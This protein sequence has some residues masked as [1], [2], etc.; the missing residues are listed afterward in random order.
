MTH[1]AWRL[2]RVA[3][4]TGSAVISTGVYAQAATPAPEQDKSTTPADVESIRSENDI[5]VT[6]VR[7]SLESALEIK[8]ASTEIVDAISADSIGKLP[9][10]NLAES[11]QRLPGVQIN[12]SALTRLGTVSLRG[13]PGEFAQVTLNGEYLA[14][15]DI[16]NFS[17]GIV[18][19]E[20]FSS[21]A[22]RK[23]QSASSM[24]GALSGLVDLRTGDP[25]AAKQGLAIAANMSYEESSG[26]WVPGGAVTFAKEIV[27]GELAV[28]A[29]VGYKA[30]NF[31]L[32]N[33]QINTYDVTAG[34]STIDRSDDV[35]VP[36]QVRLPFQKV[37]GR[38]ISASL[39]AEW[40]ITDQLTWTV[41]GF[42]NNYTADE[43]QS[44]FLVE[45]VNGSRRTV[46]GDPTDEGSLGLTYPQVRIENPRISVDTRNLDDTYETFAA[47][48][49][50]EWEND[51]WRA[52][53]TVHYT[54]ASRD[55]I[56]TGWVATQEPQAGAGNG[57]VL[58]YNSGS[59]K[60]GRGAFNLTPSASHLV[61][62]E[63]PFGTPPAPLLRQIFATGKPGASLTA[64]GRDLLLDDEE[65][66]FRFD[67]ERKF[68]GSF[69]SS[70]ALGGVYRDKKQSQSQSLMTILGTKLNMLSNSFYDN[71]KNDTGGGYFGGKLGSFDPADYG[72]LDVGAI[73]DALQ[74]VD[75]A[76]AQALIRA[77][78]PSQFNLYFVN[79]SG[80]VNY[81]DAASIAGTFRNSEK[82]YGGY[83]QANFEQD[84]G[85]SVMLRGNAGLRYEQTSR[86]TLPGVSTTSVDF[87]YGNWLPLANVIF[88]VGDNL[89]LRVSYTETMRRPSVQNFA[90]Q[91][92]I[93][94]RDSGNTVVADFGA[95]DLRPFRSQNL[96]ASIEF[97][98]R[99]GSN[100]T[101]AGFFKTVIDFAGATRLCPADGGG[102]GFGP[103]ISIG[104]VCRTTQATPSTPTQLAVN[105][106]ATVNINV[107]ANQDVFNLYGFEASIQQN[108]DFLPAPWNGFG[109][110][111]N[112]TN[113]H[114]S[115]NSAFRLSELSENTVNVILYYETPVFGL[116]AA[117]NWR[118]KYFLASGG[119]FTGAD[120][121]VAARP[122]LDLSGSV[123]LTERLNLNFE[124]FNITNA[125]LYEYEG[126]STRARN[127][128]HYGR[129]VSFGASY[130]F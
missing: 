70:I 81:L 37:D 50:L 102:L 15:P 57:F 29:A 53:G 104:G 73:K 1:N 97:Y 120:R 12:R 84:M 38:S 2:V 64:L 35:Y 31:R 114:Y 92:S 66:T 56:F 36:R 110:Q 59:G 116:R 76:A 42:Y 90:V 41:E 68:E 58:D 107:V 18:R 83:A 77:T 51:Q 123:N 9:D 82:I 45:A 99:K 22:V 10:L 7:Q 27:P 11:L 24:T 117:Y 33:F 127:Y 103:L 21:I 100:I 95:S 80:Y 74:P 124:V 106:G 4:L 19:S 115:T 126:E 5:V 129:T 89:V 6:G 30:N 71:P 118:S 16:S 79:Q 101:L 67:V 93:A 69:L 109:G 85:S 17:F 72:E 62:L 3:L 113:V 43:Y 44:Q 75:F 130:R 96:D 49:R 88:D 32:D 105:A 98:N 14:N 61:N 128:T 13:L 108:L 122:Q 55:R 87:D 94:V 20:V 25:F 60:I 23:T 112:W 39:G 65:L 52:A 46:I 86:S 111:V 48:N 78:N 125:D 91:Q 26:E 119:S 47:T 34:A 28:R 63:Q 8:K 40:R 121:M 54:K